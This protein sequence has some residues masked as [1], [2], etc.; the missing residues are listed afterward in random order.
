VTLDPEKMPIIEADIDTTVK[1]I[2]GAGTG[3][4][5]VLVERYLRFVFAG[6]VA[7]DR[8]LALTFTRKAASEMRKR[9][10][11]EAA[12]RGALPVVRQLHAAWIMNF[13]QFAVRLIRENAAAFGIDPGVDVA[14][15]LDVAR[16]RSSL[17]RRFESGRIDG[18]REEYEDDLPDPAGLRG[19]FDKW[20]AIVAK[21]R[22]TLWTVE[23][24]RASV[25]P[26]DPSAYG[27]YV[28]SVAA[29]WVAYEDELG[30]RGL[31]DFSDMI[32]IAV[33]GLS[34]N[35]RLRERYVKRFDHIL[36]DEFQDTSEAQNE[37]IRILSGG[38][39]A[40][41]TVVG[42]DKQSIYRWRDARV[43]NLREF[44]GEEKFLRVNHR[45][46]QEILDLAHHF[47][48]CDPYFESL[49]DKIRLFADRGRGGAPIC[50][51]HPA[52]GSAES[53][54]AEGKALAA[55]IL[56][57]SGRLGEGASPYACLRE[58]RQPLDFGDIAVLMRKLTSSSGLPEYEHALSEAGI[59]YS[60]SGG[61]GSVEVRALERLKDL[62]R[63][64]VYPD[65]L[66]A[67]LGVLE[68]APFSVCDA[69]LKELFDGGGADVDAILCEKALAKLSS[70]PSRAACERLRS[71]LGVLRARRLTLDLAAFVTLTLEEAPFYF[72][73]FAEGADERLVE[74]VTRTVVD[75][76][77]RLVDRNEA[78]LSAFVEALQILIDRRALDDAE[79][80]SFPAG[81][82]KIMTIHS[83]KGLEFRAVAVPGIRKP[84]SASEG[85]Y[86]SQDKGL[87]LSKGENWKRGLTDSDTYPGYKA[88][89]EQEE[90]CLLYVAM[91]RA[92]DFLFLSSPHPNGIQKGKDETYFKTV[93][94]VL[95]KHAV[96]HEELRDL[97]A[98]DLRGAIVVKP[99]EGT[100][101][102]LGRLIDN[103]AIERTRLE[104][105]RTD[106][107][108]V[109]EVE[110]VSWRRLLAFARCP[111]MYYYRYVVGLEY[112]TETEEEIRERDGEEGD[113]S[114][115]GAEIPRGIDRKLYGSFVHRVLFEWMR[116]EGART[117]D[118]EAFVDVAA[119]R[120]GFST[121]ERHAV[122]KAAGRTLRAFA[123]SPLARRE[124]VF[125]L[126]EPVE[127]RLDRLVFR[128]TIDRIE[129][130]GGLHKVIDYKGGMPA[131]EYAYQIR[132]YAWMLR[133][134]GLR[135]SSEALLCY[136]GEP[137]GLVE[138]DV[139]APFLDSIEA[140]ARRLEAAAAEGRYAA[141]PGA[142]CEDC[143]FGG[144]CPRERTTAAPN[145]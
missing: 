32:R 130:E 49:S 59:P 138:I 15:E 64:L 74:A 142:A 122:S 77:G 24:L 46:T 21:A 16:A 26:E 2:A 140:D 12:K 47:I 53:L 93:L 120:F 119:G 117:V 18:L 28:R 95:K 82:V 45:S 126:E 85:F 112:T 135:V 90:R 6:G 99:P 84:P 125:A 25:R 10:F 94:D 100:Q 69:A 136:L 86:L 19:T 66:K 30:R 143:P 31:I 23:S 33:R 3:K 57:V 70:A 22:G 4:T 39:F 132:F 92:M 144:V 145:A 111:L 127:A 129:A 63:L 58:K 115:A 48:V 88:D 110:F 75:L 73:L 52:D 102:S 36:V 107:R 71:L 96:P 121:S 137:D 5:S 80:S 54:D 124:H 17:F 79:K 131:D 43:K 9:I 101:A 65:D 11:D 40:R 34:E 141:S 83:A 139:S 97:S 7:P 118:P 20:L 134:A 113:E 60:V 41:V 72:Q 68:N 91:T 128:G 35:R 44:A 76:A 37:L 51:F 133:R 55:W 108:P 8:L 114:F 106:L 62:L 81:R 14:T 103:W 98:V 61:G 56:A 123:D 1:T 50:V 89:D 67:L 87:Y 27:R 109:R 13:H 105:A 104:A 78:N 29:L 116:S 42:D 38:D